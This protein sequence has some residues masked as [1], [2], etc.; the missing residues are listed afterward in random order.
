MSKHVAR[1]VKVNL[2]SVL[3]GEVTGK[4][5]GWKTRL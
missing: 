1:T 2:C 5:N 3:G 4:E